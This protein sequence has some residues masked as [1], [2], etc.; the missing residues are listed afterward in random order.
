LYHYG[1][2]KENPGP[3]DIKEKRD[4][5]SSSLTDILQQGARSSDAPLSGPAA[6]SEATVEISTEGRDEPVVRNLPEVKPRA[7]LLGVGT[8]TPLQGASSSNISTASEALGHLVS[9]V[10]GLC[11]TKRRYLVPLDGN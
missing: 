5:P 11:L 4:S 2:Q 3:Q 1:N 7:F 10:G 9:D 8:D 6:T